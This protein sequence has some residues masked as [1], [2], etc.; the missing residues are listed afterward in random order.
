MVIGIVIGNLNFVMIGHYNDFYFK[1]KRKLIK[2]I[3][4]SVYKSPITS[5]FNLDVAV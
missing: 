2:A 3:E 1:K 5:I 4:M